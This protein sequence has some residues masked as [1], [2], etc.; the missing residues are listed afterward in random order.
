MRFHKTAIAMGLA[1]VLLA[2]G[3]VTWLAAADQKHPLPAGVGDLSNAAEVEVRDGAGQAVLRGRLG[4]NEEEGDDGE[5]KAR[6]EPAA[7]GAGQGQA[8]VE[9]RRNADGAL[10][11]QE[12]EISVEKLAAGATFT[13]HVDGK[14]VGSVTTDAKGAA[15]VEFV[16]AAAR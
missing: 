11:R 2:G 10:V 15:E 5:K 9:V 13:I 7:G 12:V 1:A 4:P 3:G 16:S 8:E 14:Q 6:L